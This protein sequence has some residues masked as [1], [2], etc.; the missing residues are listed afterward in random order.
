MLTDS[1]Q[2]PNVSVSKPHKILDVCELKTLNTRTNLD[3]V[4]RLALHVVVLGVSGYLWGSASSWLKFPALLLY[5]I[6]L[7]MMFC[8]TH[9]CV[10]RTAFANSRTND[11]VG[12]L[13]G[14]LSFYNSTFYRY[15]HKWHHRYTQIAGKDPE[16]DDPK[17]EN[18]GQYL[19]RLSGASWWY[20]KIKG[21]L[22]I[23]F[24]QLEDYYFLPQSSYGDVIS[25]TRLQLGTYIA[26]ALLSTALGH[27]WFIVTYWLLPLAL[28]QP[29]LRFVLIAEHTGCTNDDNPLTNTRTTLTIWPLRLLMWNMPY[30]AEHHL[31]PSIPF[32]A[33]PKAHQKLKDSF[34][35]VD[36]GYFQVNRSIISALQ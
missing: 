21:H 30:H 5:G 11:V 2:A 14:L 24:R 29:F 10:H 34:S 1:T 31:Y 7:A 35:R 16:L 18:L 4:A 25:S 8:P 28:G 15:Y 27:P 19:W 23:S 6:G 12:W 17:P 22:K 26:I 32:H 9:E 33:L 36:S 20:D 3:G 13:A